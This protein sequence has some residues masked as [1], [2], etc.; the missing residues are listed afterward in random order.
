M[1][2]QPKDTKLSFDDIKKI[3]ENHELNEIKKELVECFICLMIY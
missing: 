1:N 3:K 2:I